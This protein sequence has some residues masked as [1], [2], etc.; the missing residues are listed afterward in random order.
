MWNQCWVWRTES[1]SQIMWS[2]YYAPVS[3]RLWKKNKPFR[4]K[5]KPLRRWMDSQQALF[6][7]TLT[8]ECIV[9]LLLLLMALWEMNRI[10]VRKL[11]TFR[12]H[13]WLGMFLCWRLFPV[14]WWLLGLCA[15]S[16]ASRD[17]CQCWGVTVFLLFLI[18][19]LLPCS[20]Y[21]KT[22]A[23]CH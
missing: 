12:R 7:V 23:C 13:E 19:E 5:K 22:Q 17:E 4:S 15:A 21:F 6:S 10:I 14:L 1:I 16:R 20:V 18:V 2:F 11:V 9:W 8:A 3:R